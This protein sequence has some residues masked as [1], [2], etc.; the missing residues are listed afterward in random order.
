MKLRT[1]LPL[2]VLFVC[3]LAPAQELT[4][5]KKT[6]LLE[7]ISQHVKERAY[8]A[9][10]DFSRW[11]EFVSKYQDDFEK[12]GTNSSFASSVN[13]ALGE[14]GFSHI[15]LLTPRSAQTRRTGKSVGIGVMVETLET[16][17]RIV[18]VIPGGPAEKAGLQ[19]DDIIVKGD[20]RPVNVPDQI[21]GEKG[22]TVSLTIHRPDGSE[23]VITVKRSE[24][25]VL[26]KDEM[27]WVDEKTVLITLNSF[28]TGYSR[29]EVNRFF[30]EAVG[31]ERM[32]IDIRSNGGGSVPNLIH[33]GSR[34]LARG[35]K[36]GKFITRVDANAFLKKYPEEDT[37]PVKVAEEFGF[38]LSV[39][40]R[41][42]QE[43]FEGPLVVLINRGSASASEMFAS[44]IRDNGRGKLIG[45][46][47]AGAVLASTFLR[48][49]EGFSLQI[50]L[51]EYVTSSGLRLEGVGVLPDVEIKLGDIQN[52]E[53][54]I[55]A[56]LEALDKL[57]K[58]AQKG[59]PPPPSKP[60]AA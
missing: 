58:E 24:F 54:V 15:R 9:G 60:R 53:L 20:G 59:G 11:D 35:S 2:L 49:P 22:T 34:V 27:K 52:D 38:L 48:L 29:A 5:E 47:T 13:R 46:R 42:I 41:G 31:A 44:A 3:G 6:V 56:A 40:G 21:R 18:R 17:L 36:F 1:L 37:D 4:D 50:P 10:A 25:S 57:K 8:A 55:K 28:A 19:V 12:A 51:M 16:G 32:I 30:R 7:A 33:F 23:I 14:F 26:Q 45:T 39:G 43:P